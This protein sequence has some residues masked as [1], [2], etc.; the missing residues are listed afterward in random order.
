MYKFKPMKPVTPDFFNTANLI[1]TTVMEANCGPEKFME[2]LSG[3]TVWT[4]W[5]P[6]L[7]A[8]EWTS[9]KPFAKGATRTVYLV[10]NHAVKEDFFIWEENKRIAFYV[11]ESTMNGVES[12]AEDYVLDELGNNRT[13]L[14]WT[15]AMQLTGIGKF[16]TPFAR[17]G[18]S[19][20]FS[21][22]LNSYRK[23]LE[24]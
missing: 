7:K 5:A 16:F 23:I 18:M 24:S 21:R 12:F 2:T 15:V 17:I 22:W 11:V 20:V 9:E 14:T 13:R 4:E 6:S 10:G 19:F 3:D 1:V 8:V